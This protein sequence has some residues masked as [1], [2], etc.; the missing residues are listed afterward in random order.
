MHMWRRSVASTCN[1]QLC[2]T[3]SLKKCS[4]KR[5]ASTCNKQHKG[6]D[7]CHIDCHLGWRTLVLKCNK[8]N[9]DCHIESSKKMAFSHLQLF[10]SFFCGACEH[11]SAKH[12]RVHSA[13]VF[14]NVAGRQPYLRS[15]C[16]AT[17]VA[18][19]APIFQRHVFRTMQRHTGRRQ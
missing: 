9:Y 10:V 7:M 16:H 11:A 8:N 3:E 6:E 15:R 2:H 18:T 12:A 17:S 14:P 1:K 4:E 19:H 13:R 5:M